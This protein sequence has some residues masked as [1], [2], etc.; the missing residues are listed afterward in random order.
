[1]T[2]RIAIPVFGARVSSR[3]DCS[4]SVLLISVEEGQAV[5][6]EESRWMHLNQ[7]GRM[8]LLVREGVEV[9]ICGGLTEVCENFLRDTGIKVIP[10]VRGEVDEVLSQYLGGTLAT[11]TPH[12]NNRTTA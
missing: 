2:C 5:R 4:E 12:H 8:D 3:L 1:V 10:W 11:T 9:L 7:L 6:R